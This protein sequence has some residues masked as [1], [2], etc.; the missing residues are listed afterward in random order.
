MVDVLMRNESDYIELRNSLIKQFEGE[1]SWIYTDHRGYPTIGWGFNIQGDSNLRRSVYTA[2]N[3]PAAE[4]GDDLRTAL[5]N[6]IRAYS[7][8]NQT[9]ETN[10]LKTQLDSVLSSYAP[11]LLEAGYDTNHLRSHRSANC[12]SV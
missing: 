9:G 8:P 6:A 4:A 3:I 5:D 11:A 12:H 1:V 2:L 7:T 10:P